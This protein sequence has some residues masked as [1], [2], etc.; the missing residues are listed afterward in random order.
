MK[1]SVLAAL[2]A[3]IILIPQPCV[4]AG[5]E[6]TSPAIRLLEKMEFQKTA[7]ESAAGMFEPMMEQFAGIGLPPEALE[8][9]RGAT[10]KFMNDIFTDPAMFKGI[11]KIYEDHFTAAE[12]EELIQLYESPLGR[13][14]I[15]AQPAIGQATA[16]LTMK[17]TAE[18]QAKFQQEIMKI[19]EKH[20]NGDAR[21]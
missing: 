19:M 3:M 4:F 11:A 8:E 12:L 9:I 20:Q 15:A 1:K 10:Q 13:K 16:Q 17:A 5:E 6:E 7:V 14:L 21:K 2:C 18:N